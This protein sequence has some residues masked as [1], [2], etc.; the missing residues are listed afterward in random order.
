MSKSIQHLQHR[1]QFVTLLTI[2]CDE[3]HQFLFLVIARHHLL[4][5]VVVLYILPFWV[6]V[7]HQV[8]AAFSQLP[9]DLVVVLDGRF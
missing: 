9:D 7:L 3:L 6:V 5:L 1:K 4:F 2:M 8:S